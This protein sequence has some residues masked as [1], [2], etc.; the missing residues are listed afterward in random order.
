MSEANV[1]TKSPKRIP[2]W[3]RQIANWVKTG[4]K[5]ILPYAALAIMLYAI[6]FLPNLTSY[7]KEVE[8]RWLGLMFQVIGL[9][10]V[11]RQLNDRLKLFRKPS[12]LSSIRNYWRRFP[13]KSTKNISLSARASFGVLTGNARISVRRRSISSLESR[14][15]ALEG[16][17]EDLR[18]DIGVVEKTLN[19]HE[20]DNRNS[21]EMMRKEN[22]KSYERLERLVDEAVVGGTHLEWVGILYL[23]AGI[24]LAT[25]APEFAIWSGYGGECNQ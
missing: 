4:L 18:R 25:T 5:N 15:E 10:I 7:C 19:R 1:T 21:L 22:R 23:L 13:S 24:L 20:E 11:V 3:I 9:I 2:L 6:V 17:M 16:E 8:I 12:F 14:I